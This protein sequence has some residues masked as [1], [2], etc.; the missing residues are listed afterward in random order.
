MLVFH[1]TSVTIQDNYDIQV[2]VTGIGTVSGL[3]V[4]SYVQTPVVDFTAP[5]QVSIVVRPEDRD[6]LLM[7]WR[8]SNSAFDPHDANIP[9]HT[10][11]PNAS[12]RYW[13]VR[14]YLLHPEAVLDRIELIPE[15]MI[16]K[17]S[18]MTFN[19]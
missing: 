14:V 10:G 13:Q 18:D 6:N 17:H 16:G 4:Q 8:A 15:Q 1:Y 11:K 2:Q 9:W 12:Y 3:P 19:L 5:Q 7:I